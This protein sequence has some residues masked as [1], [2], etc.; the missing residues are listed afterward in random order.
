MNETFAKANT[1]SPLRSLASGTSLAVTK[2]RSLSQNLGERPSPEIHTSDP[3]R[4]T[5]VII[6]V[7]ALEKN[8]KL[9]Q[10]LAGP[11]N[12]VL[13][14]V[15]ADAYGHGAVVCAK[16]LE[17]AGAKYLGVATVE[18]A[19]ELRKA[20][21]KSPILVFDGLVT[22]NLEVFFDYQLTPV[23]HHVTELEKLAAFLK[24]TRSLSVHLKVDTGMG[25]LGL[26]ESEMKTWVPLLQE[27]KNIKV[28]G[29]MTHLAKAD[30]H[31][32]STKKQTSLFFKIKNELEKSIKK[33][34]PFFHYANS[35]ALLDR[36]GQEGNIVRPGIMLYGAYPHVRQKKNKLVPVMTWEA[37]IISL[38]KFPKGSELSYGG[39]FKTKQES[40]IATLSVGYADGLPRLLS[41]KGFVLVN[42]KRCPIVGRVC[43]DLTLVDVTSVP[44]VKIG[45]P[46]VLIGK[47]GKQ[48]IRAE[49]MADWAQTISY[50][51][52]CGV[53]KRVPRFYVF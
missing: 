47:Q 41:N 21:M 26:F 49:E 23:I 37:S 25:R 40:L 34:I 31:P 8:F 42:G 33:S 46:V 3:H 50:E 28:E 29:V 22:G 44:G 6:S 52:F 12:L 30:T 2:L 7:K 39:T 36:L 48:E 20:K 14:V 53:S 10:A 5:R 17:K 15:K 38:K 1:F 16:V 43:M 19:I 27:N 11:K 24:K 51:I 9:A 18:E 32:A 4:K 45:A 13:G 35:A